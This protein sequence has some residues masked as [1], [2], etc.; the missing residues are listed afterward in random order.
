[1]NNITI[2]DLFTGS[3]AFTHSFKKY[4]KCNIIFANDILDSSE[5]IFNLNNN[6]EKKI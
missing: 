2:V 6:S 4:N 5:L 1:M 3:G